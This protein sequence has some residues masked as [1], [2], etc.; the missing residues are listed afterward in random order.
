[1]TQDDERAHAG[2]PADG[3][4]DVNVR[5]DE[6]AQ[7]D[8]W[9][10]DGWAEVSD[11]LQALALKLKLH[12]RQVRSETGAAEAHTGEKVTGEVEPRAEEPTG[13]ADGVAEALEAVRRGIEDAFDA[14][15]NAIRD[16]AVRADFRDLGRLLSGNL[17]ASWSRA[18]EDIKDLLK[19]R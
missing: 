18:T 3:Q 14:A 10:G 2:R 8:Q 13:K 9:A 4:S 15:G 1:M 5:E 16:E 7:D 17:S 11:R 19:R 6:R 12:L